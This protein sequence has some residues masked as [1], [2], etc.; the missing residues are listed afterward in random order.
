MSQPPNRQPLHPYFPDRPSVPYGYS[1]GSQPDAV[2]PGQAFGTYDPTA[3]IRWRLKWLRIT[4]VALLLWCLGTVWVAVSE[5]HPHHHNPYGATPVVAAVTI[6]L[7]IVLYTIKIRKT[8]RE[9]R[10]AARA[11][12]SPPGVISSPPGWQPGQR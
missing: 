6:F 5:M 8:K 2:P 1:I 10:A 7:I 4:W 12:G 9:L 11:A 3:Q